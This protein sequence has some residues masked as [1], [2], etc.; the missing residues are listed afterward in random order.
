[1]KVTFPALKGTIGRRTY[2]AC[3]MAL[4][5]VPRFFKFNDSEQLDPSH[6]AQ[7]VLNQARVPEIT[8]YMLENEEGYLFSSITASYTCPVRF[9]PTGPDGD[10]G[11]L[12]MDFEE[13]E[14]IINDGQH[15]VA[16]I[17]AALKENP[18][19]GKERI[20]VLLFEMENLDRVQQMFSDLNRF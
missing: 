14:F 6:R 2:Y 17:A 11:E 20:S 1:M 3:T 8:R 12:E 15:R 16:A 10:M 19:L 7:R 4:S 18:A 5:E 9:I 13:M